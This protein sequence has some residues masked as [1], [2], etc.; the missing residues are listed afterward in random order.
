VAFGTFNVPKLAFAGSLA[1]V[2]LDARWTSTL[3]EAESAAVRGL[4]LAAAAAD[5]WPQ[6]TSTGPL[7]PELDSGPH[8]L[9]YAGELAA[10]GNLKEGG[11]AFGRQVAEV[12]VHPEH[13]GRGH[14][15]ALV[16]A[17]IARSTGTLRVWS[18]ADHPAAAALARARGFDRVRELLRMRADLVERP[19]PE[20][21][22]GVRL[23][24]FEPGVDEQAVVDVNARAFSW[25]PE[26]G[27]M[28]V[29][30]LRAAEGEPWF[31]PE[32]FFVAEG[33]QRLLGFHWT[34]IHSGEGGSDPVGEVYVVGVDPDAHGGGL[35][36]ALT[37]AGL[38]Y[39]QKRG[40]T[41]VIL[42][43]EGDNAPAL[44]VYRR[45]GF[46][47]ELTAVQYERRVSGDAQAVTAEA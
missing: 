31:D 18:H 45:L 35:G 23:R 7:P 38:N 10:Y 42:Y 44:A 24:T 46:D 3:T 36:R 17:V 21:Q 11:D 39:L 14:G 27:A 6:L 47:V 9:G 2:L 28:T 15:G 33:E 26:Q 8:L 4:L 43:V 25:H 12:I 37:V 13:R 5:G 1:P 40:L 22:P 32:G 19:A 41:R 30:D 20:L 34:K 29:S 16:D